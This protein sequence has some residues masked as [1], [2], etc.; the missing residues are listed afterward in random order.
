MSDFQFKFD[1]SDASDMQSGQ[2]WHSQ[3]LTP[4]TMAQFQNR[5]QKFLDQK[6]VLRYEIENEQSILVPLA[7]QAPKLK[8][9]SLSEILKTR[10]STIEFS[11]D[12]V[13]FQTLSYLLRTALTLNRPGR[14]PYPSAGALYPVQVSVLASNVSGLSSGLYKY[15]SKKQHLVEIFQRDQMPNIYQELGLVAAGH[16]PF[17]LIFTAQFENIQEKY[18]ERGWRFIQFEV[19]SMLQSLQLVATSLGL[20]SSAWGSGYDFDLMAITKAHPSREIYMMTM[21]FGYQK[22]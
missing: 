5:I 10:K 8:T 22:S 13:D 16:P 7:T 14:R 17:S 11:S 4:E 15:V 2:A 3:V 12:A 18:G 20:G 1:L 21:L 19:G 9:D 6:S